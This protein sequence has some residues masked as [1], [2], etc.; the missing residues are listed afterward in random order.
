MASRLLPSALSL[1][2]AAVPWPRLRMQWAPVCTC[3][4]LISPSPSRPHPSSACTIPNQTC[5]PPSPCIL[6]AMLRNVSMEL[7][8]RLTWLSGITGRTRTQLLCART[9]A[10]THT[11]TRLPFF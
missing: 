5:V 10:D 3:S 1:A 8:G 2:E 6:A 9:Q 4:D 11:G 7:G